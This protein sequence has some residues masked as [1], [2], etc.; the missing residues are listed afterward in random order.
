MHLRVYAHIWSGHRSVRT[1]DSVYSL[2]Q[3]RHLYR[4]FGL[5]S[6][7]SVIDN[8]SRDHT[9]YSTAPLYRSREVCA[10]G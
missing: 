3:L 2:L 4:E 9:Q 7:R 8:K 5:K 10:A 1:I 6:G